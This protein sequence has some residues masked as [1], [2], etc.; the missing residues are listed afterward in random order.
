MEVGKDLWHKG[1]HISEK[2]GFLVLE[3][4]CN[5]VWKLKYPS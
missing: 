2:D 5:K 1:V 4:K 3:K